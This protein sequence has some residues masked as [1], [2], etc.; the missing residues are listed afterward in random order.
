MKC[1]PERAA[2]IISQCGPVYLLCVSVGTDESMHINVRAGHVKRRL[3]HL[4]LSY[5]FVSN[6]LYHDGLNCTGLNNAI[7]FSAYFKLI[8]L[9]L[10]LMV[11]VYNNQRIGLVLD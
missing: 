6:T 11:V 9:L 5:I 2:D 10:K 7:Q 8:S 4:I 3:L 1:M